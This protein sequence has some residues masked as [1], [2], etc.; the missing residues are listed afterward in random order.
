MSGRDWYEIQDLKIDRAHLPGLMM[1]IPGDDIA[2]PLFHLVSPEYGE[3]SWTEDGRGWRIDAFKEILNTFSREDLK[4]LKYIVRYDD[5]NYTNEF[6]LNKKELL[7]E[8][9]LINMIHI[10]IIEK[11]TVFPAVRQT[12]QEMLEILKD[13][14]KVKALYGVLVHGF[15]RINPIKMPIMLIELMAKFYI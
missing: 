14:F 8:E 4:T 5:A 12:C 7:F 10:S 6:Y 3:S 13:K 2:P 1:T 15:C 9:Y 11:H